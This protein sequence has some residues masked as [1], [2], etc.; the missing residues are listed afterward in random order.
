M[1]ALTRR[2]GEEVVIG[3]PA[4]PLGVIRVVELHGDKVRLSFDFPREVQINR[5]ELADQ[6]AQASEA[7]SGPDQPAQD[8]S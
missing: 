6:K 2:A 4:N 1:L 8:E 5:K 3:D 7:A